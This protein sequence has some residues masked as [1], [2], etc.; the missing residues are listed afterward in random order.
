MRQIG[1]DW[2]ILLIFNLGRE[3]PFLI[4]YQKGSLDRDPETFS[5]QTRFG[6]TR[7]VLATYISERHGTAKASRLTLFKILRLLCKVS[8]FE[9]QKPM[10]LEII[11]VLRKSLPVSLPTDHQQESR[12][13]VQSGRWS[14]RRSRMLDQPFRK[15]QIA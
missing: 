8:S 15:I 11:Y 4:N 1:F 9:H 3:R 14:R 5:S 13:H 12:S 10:A 7:T 2:V 6:V